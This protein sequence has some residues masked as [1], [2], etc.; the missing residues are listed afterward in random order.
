MDNWGLLLGLVFVGSALGGLLRY[1]VSVWVGRRLGEAFPVGTLVVNVTGA[2]VAGFAWTFAWPD[3][4]GLS[5]PDI[6]IF[7]LFGFLGGYTTVSSYALNSFALLRDGQWKG[8]V[9]NLLG[10]LFLCLAA[11]VGG[12][13]IGGG[14]PFLS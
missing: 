5:G 12:A 14:T 13:W 3:L 1:G 2:F 8:A 9:Q 11:G 6:R 7:L 10:T 4:W